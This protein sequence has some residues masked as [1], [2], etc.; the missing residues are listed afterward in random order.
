VDGAAAGEAGAG[1]SALGNVLCGF[2][3]AEGARPKG[4]EVDGVDEGPGGFEKGYACF[5]AV[6]G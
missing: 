3:K 6:A 4:F 1:G 2:G 5:S